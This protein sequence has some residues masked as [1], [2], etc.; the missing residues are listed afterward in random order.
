[1]NANLQNILAQYNSS[2]ARASE[3]KVQD[4]KRRKREEKEKKQAGPKGGDAGGKQLKSKLKGHVNGFAPAPKPKPSTTA[5]VLQAH[6]NSVSSVS[7]TSAPLAK[8]LK[9]VLDTLLQKVGENLTPEEVL[10]LS[11][12]NL[13]ADAELLRE[14]QK[15]PRIKTGPGASAGRAA[16]W[17]AYRPEIEGVHDKTSLVNYVRDLRGRPVMMEVLKKSYGRASED[18]Q[19]LRDEGKVLIIG[20]P[21]PAKEV[22]FMCDMMGM[23]SVSDDVRGLWYEVTMDVQGRVPVPGDTTEL[24]NAVT[25]A[26]L[27]SALAHQPMKRVM[28]GAKQGRAKARKPR[29]QRFNPEKATNAHMPQLFSSSQPKGY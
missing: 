14:V 19:Q 15:H 28:P 22:V 29:Q 1:M 10:Q 11:G 4:E 9:D 21:D 13:R 27:R 16:E 25:R 23:Q 12:H 7:P 6:Q 8:R 17:Y 26:G 2:E 20:N 3:K 24:Q 5:G 18:L